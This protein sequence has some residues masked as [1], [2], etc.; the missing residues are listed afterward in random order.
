MYPRSGY[1]SPGAFDLRISQGKYTPT[2]LGEAHMRVTETASDLERVERIINEGFPCIKN[3]PFRPVVAFVA[4][5]TCMKQKK[6]NV[7]SGPN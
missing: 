5:F 2:S 7:V 6:N 1:N 3:G 4:T